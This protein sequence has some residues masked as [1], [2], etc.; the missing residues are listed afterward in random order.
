MISTRGLAIGGLL[1]GLAVLGLSVAFFRLDL[2]AAEPLHGAYGDQAI[3]A[4]ELASTPEQLAAVIG[5]N[6]PSAEAQAI[7]RDMD[8][9]NRLDFAYMACYGAFIALVCAC[10]A[11]RRE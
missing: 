10:A 7:R 4:F 11:R 5:S 1:A 8:R 6:P 3:L 9:A 2:R